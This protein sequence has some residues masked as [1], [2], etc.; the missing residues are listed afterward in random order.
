MGDDGDDDQI[1]AIA[2]QVAANSAQLD[3][4]VA[5]MS[6][7]RDELHALS[8]HDADG[9][10]EGDEEGEEEGDEENDEDDTDQ[11]G[12]STDEDEDD[13]IF[14]GMGGL[15]GGN[16]DDEEDG[17]E[18]DDDNESSEEEDSQ[19]G[20]ILGGMFSKSV[21]ASSHSVRRGQYSSLVAGI[22]G[23]VAGLAL[24]TLAIRRCSK[25]SDADAIGDADDQQHDQNDEGAAHG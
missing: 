1:D 25:R 4:L 7:F 17:D 18:G 16:D 14:S 13:G 11:D 9:D 6:E 19:S 20:G 23:F 10:I 3:E 21:D 8:A 5:G 24:T 2:D 22:G 15:F 12:E